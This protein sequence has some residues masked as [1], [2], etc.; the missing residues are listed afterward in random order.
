LPRRTGR[1]SHTT[2]VAYLALFVAL[3]GSAYAAATITGRDVVDRSLTGADI[4]NGSVRSAD[5]RNITGA[6]LGSGQPWTLRSPNR[7][8]SVAVTNSGVTI[9]GPG[10]EVVVNNAGVTVDGAASTEISAGA[11][12]DLN[13]SA[14]VSLNGALVQLRGGCAPLADANK[15]FQHT[16]AE[17]GGS[18][19][20]GQGAKPFL[21]P[22]LL[23]C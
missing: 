19:G 11:N 9:K 1:I 2:V 17:T 10:S 20:P 21:S 22:S 8:F 12:L 3:G 18:T 13:A 7:R 16:H 23:G 6:D 5:V 14:S 4:R 15:V